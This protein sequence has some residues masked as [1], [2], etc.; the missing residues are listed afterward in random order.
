[1]SKNCKRI[2][3]GINFNFNGITLCSSIWNKDSYIPY[4]KD[5]IN[6]FITKRE[7]VIRNAQ[8]GILP[9]YCKN[10]NMHTTDEVNENSTNKIKF[11]EIYHWYQCNCAC[12]Y[13]SNRHF[14]KLKITNSKN[15]KGIINVMPMLNKL[16]ELNILDENAQI[17]MVGGEPTLLRELVDILKFAIKHKY[18]ISLLSNGILYEKYISKTL[19]EIPNSTLIVSIDSGTKEMFKK[20]KGVD[21][22][23]DVIKNLKR[24]IDETK[25]NSYRIM[26]KYILL[27]GVND[28]TDEIDKWI[29]QSAE[30]GITNFFPTIEFCN[31][32][33][34]PNKQ[35]ISEEICQLYDYMKRKIKEVNP[36]FRVSTYSFVEEFVKNRSYKVFC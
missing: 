20:I 27:P 34:D 31:A 12:F 4:E 13:C 17:S 30:I 18:G 14:T 1:M 5:Y 28:N 36:A 16:Q 6:T 3:N 32:A 10:C 26:S 23:N 7:E 22:Y 11:I 19:N 35:D 21:K 29:E 25:D 2:T 9:D 24:Y 15:Q 33:L 8:N